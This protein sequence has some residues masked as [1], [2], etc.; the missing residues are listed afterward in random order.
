MM[1]VQSMVL[2]AN[3]YVLA[4]EDV[5]NDIEKEELLSVHEVVARVKKSLEEAKHTRDVLQ[6]G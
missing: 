4:C 3:G 2:Y 1:T 6:D 5:L